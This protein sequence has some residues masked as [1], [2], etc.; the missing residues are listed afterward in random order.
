MVD[1]FS[2]KYRQQK[3]A[4]ILPP[5]FSGSDTGQAGRKKERLT[6]IKSFFFAGAAQKNPPTFNSSIQDI[7]V[8]VSKWLLGARDRGGRRSLQQKRKLP[9]KE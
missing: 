7:E 6:V 3:F 5:R 4:R 8:A 9:Q 2:A 1:F